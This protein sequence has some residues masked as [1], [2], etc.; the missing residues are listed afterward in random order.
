MKRFILLTEK[1][2]FYKLLCLGVCVC[3]SLLGFPANGGTSEGNESVSLTAHDIPLAEVLEI[4]SKSTGY[5]FAISEEWLDYPISVSFDSIPLH[6]ALKRIFADF[7]SAVIYGSNKKIKIIIYDDT[8]QAESTSEKPKA[9]KPPTNEKSQQQA[10][11][12]TETSPS[13]SKHT[14]NSE[15]SN[16]IQDALDEYQ[17]FEETPEENLM[18]S[19]PEESTDREE[20]EGTAESGSS[21]AGE[22]ENSENSDRAEAGENN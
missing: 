19:Q 5:E 13:D 11:V 6:K 7:N 4:L 2:L 1:H 15:E 21:S 8:S 10:A 3:F 18:K 9:K 12:D 16:S 22:T 14:E 20:S 17:Q